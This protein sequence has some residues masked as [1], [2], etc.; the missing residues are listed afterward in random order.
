MSDSE[1]GD[2][3]LHTDTT[4]QKGKEA[5]RTE[6]QVANNV[7]Q[8]VN[9]TLVEVV[10]LD[11]SDSENDVCTCGIVLKKVDV[12]ELPMTSTEEDSVS[13]SDPDFHPS[14]S[15]SDSESAVRESSSQ[16]LEEEEDSLLQNTPYSS[17]E[18]FLQS[19]K[20]KN[21]TAQ[22]TTST[23]YKATNVTEVSHFENKILFHA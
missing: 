23:K 14:H 6:F 3:E 12:V 9:K 7:E 16:Y 21:Q 8:A 11:S 19:T 4:A 17:L 22:T 13:E 5:G 18:F 10:V 1:K 2:L 15:G 20:R